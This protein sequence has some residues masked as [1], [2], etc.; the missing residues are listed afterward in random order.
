ML[1][2]LILGLQSVL[3]ERG[4]TISDPALACWRCLRSSFFHCQCS[5]QL[6]ATTVMNVS[7]QYCH[8]QCPPF[9]P[10]HSIHTQSLHAA[11]CTCTSVGP[12][13]PTAA[14]N[15]MTEDGQNS[16][17]SNVETHNG[18]TESNRVCH[19]SNSDSWNDNNII[20]II[21]NNLRAIEQYVRT[22]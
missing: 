20:N 13:S 19:D 1:C 4:S 12:L 21:N 9:G 3:G 17:N 15:Y 22:G 16:N 2:I 8:C 10:K 11:W 6:Q 5:F 18:N 7:L 14:G